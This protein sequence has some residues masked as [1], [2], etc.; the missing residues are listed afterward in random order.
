MKHSRQVLLLVPLALAAYIAVHYLSR[1]GLESLPELNLKIIDGSTVDLASVDR[2]VLIN[3]W[4]TTCSVCMQELPEMIELYHDISDKDV[5][6]VAI[7]MPYDPPN[8]VLEAVKQFGIPYPIALDI[9]GKAMQ[10][11]GDVAA[12]PAT[13]L[14]DT[15]RKLVVHNTGRT[16][17]THLKRTVA[18]WVSTARE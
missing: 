15:N 9:N 8:L 5:Q 3:F 1:S 18:E 16:D 14:F 13:F 10:E 12:T 4:A 6:M 7:A 2:P 11:F 17:F